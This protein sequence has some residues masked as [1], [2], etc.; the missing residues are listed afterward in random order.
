MH[1]RKPEP[2]ELP[3][4]RQL[5]LA[6]LA[7][8]AVVILLTIA[9]ILP[10]ERGV[11]PTGIGDRLNLTRM[12]ILKSA[13]SEPEVPHD[14]RP[15]RSD[16]LSI[17]IPPGEGKEIKMDMKRGFEVSY[18]WQATAPIF[19]DTHSDVYDNEDVF[20]THSRAESTLN[21]TGTI[22]A[23]FGGGHG[24]YW[25]NRSD[26]PITVTVQATGE[27]LDIAEK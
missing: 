27:Y 24:W 19:H 21:D 12:G 4:L 16:E 6:S 26:D 3:G 1:I 2:D 8:V 7:A 15:Q 10:A 23:P 14:N 11:D 20:I 13:M 25:K 17:T 5:Q 22:I 9:V 18:R